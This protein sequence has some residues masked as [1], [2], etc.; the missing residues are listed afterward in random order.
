M[1]SGEL[2]LDSL[3]PFDNM[4]M[5][6]NISR[7]EGWEEIY[8]AMHAQNQGEG[9]DFFEVPTLTTKMLTQFWWSWF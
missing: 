8:V 4:P 1:I 5:I 7:D 3:Q 2:Y 6:V 9:F